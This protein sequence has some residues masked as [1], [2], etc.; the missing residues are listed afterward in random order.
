MSLVYCIVTRWLQCVYACY[1]L[2]LFPSNL[3]LVSL[4]LELILAQALCTSILLQRNCFLMRLFSSGRSEITLSHPLNRAFNGTKL[5]FPCASRGAVGRGHVS[6]PGRYGT[7]KAVFLV[8][9]TWSCRTP[10]RIAARHRTP[11]TAPARAA[12]CWFAARLG[13][14][15]L[16]W[17]SRSTLA[18]TPRST[19]LPPLTP[20]RWV[21]VS[22]PPWHNLQRMTGRYQPIIS[23]SIYL[24][25]TQPAALA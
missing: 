9:S 5:S 14:S 20:R 10:A 17:T 2:H 18:W 3:F 1:I 19:A 21:A 8:C 25:S 7:D 11:S 23:L 13:S 22:L 24:S 15:A 16:P 4:H 12:S 6:L